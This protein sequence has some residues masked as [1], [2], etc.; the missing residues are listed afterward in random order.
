MV[1]PSLFQATEKGDEAK[2][3]HS[4]S[5]YYDFTGAIDNIYSSLVARLAISERFGRY[6][7]WENRAE[8]EKVGQGA[9]GLHKVTYRSGVAHLDIYFADNISDEMRDLFMVF[10]EDHLRNEGVEI[11]E[12][13]EIICVCGYRFQEVS[14]RKRLVNGYGD[15]ICPECEK[16]SHISEGA[17]KARSSNPKMEKKLI[18]LKTTIDKK[19]KNDVD[20]A[21]KR[22]SQSTERKEDVIRIL[23]LSDFH[24][25]LDSDPQTM[26]QQLIADLK[27][28]S[29]GL[30]FEWL[31]YL[32]ISGDLSNRASPKEFENARQI[33]S[34]L[35][36]EFQ[37][38]AERCIIVPGNHDL[39]WEESVYEGKHQRLVD[40]KSLKEDT[41]V[42]QGDAILIRNDERYPLR[43][44]NF[45]EKFYHLLIQ[46][47]YP[48]IYEKQ[49]IPFL[50]PDTKIQFLAIN[51][52]WQI[53]AFHPTRSSI[54]AHALSQG[55]LE[56]NEQIKEE[57]LL[58]ED[59]QVLRIAVW[60]HP[61]TGNEKIKDDA[62]L[63]RL[64]QAGFQMCLHGHVHEE[65][66]ELIGYL[67]PTRKIHVVGAGS[68]GAPV[69]DRPESIPRLYNVIEI[70]RDHRT[71]RVHT[72][73]LRK[74]EGAW[75]GWAVWPGQ[76]PDERR[77]Y[78]EIK[79][80]KPEIGFNSLY[81]DRNVIFS[82]ELAK[83]ALVPMPALSL[84]DVKLSH[85]ST[86]FTS[87]HNSALNYFNNI[88]MLNNRIFMQNVQWKYGIQ[89]HKPALALA[90]TK[91]QIN[92]A[93][94]NAV[95]PES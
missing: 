90:P 18:A 26:L 2:I 77:T 59:A 64:R 20:K 7:L 10:I 72:R 15:I 30:G 67:H 85:V 28:R 44:K 41:Y 5:L 88:E 74:D 52:C 95:P 43:F 86:K 93:P 84:K 22:V 78:Y 70:T 89:N 49:C 24:M 58:S 45:G 68:F 37:L 25:K 82:R 31:D 76:T 47:E 11:T 14:I 79:L 91:L 9:C 40:L 80:T 66:A 16:R 87:V 63:D 53:D 65:L 56:A 42:K 13:I 34:G 19:C 27:D 46:K 33:I 36:E 81:R 92:F 62:F 23:H 29:G 12:R 75:E 1:F 73:C 39:N 48:L 55:L 57:G 17:R 61:V 60:H 32:V 21:I 71:I 50:F 6:R 38:T 3:P 69:Y 4:I 54:Y 94:N 51:S 83:M 35:I 8:F